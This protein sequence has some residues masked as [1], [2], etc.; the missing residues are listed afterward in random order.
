MNQD[1]LR[2]V[3]RHSVNMVFQNLDFSRIKL[4]L[5]IRVGLEIRV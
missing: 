2:Q 5:K 3:R 1:E 4:F